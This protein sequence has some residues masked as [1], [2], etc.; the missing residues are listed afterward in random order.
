MKSFSL[1][2]KVAALYV[3]VGSLW[4]IISDV[5][6]NY[7]L[8]LGLVAGVPQTLKGIVFIA[9]TGALLF[10]IIR[11]MD[12]SRSRVEQEAEML[13]SAAKGSLDIIALHDHDGKILFITPSVANTL[14]YEPSDFIN[15]HPS[16]L[17]HPDDIER[18]RTA[19]RGVKEG[20]EQ[21]F[22][23]RAKHKNG[24]YI[25]LESKLK[26]ILDPATQ[27]V[28]RFEAFTRDVSEREQAYRALQQ[29]EA[30]ARNIIDASPVPSALNDKNQRIIYLNPAFIAMFGYTLDDIPTLAEWWVKAYPD[31]VYRQWVQETWQLHLEKA[32]REGTTFEPMEL[33][34]C[35]KDGGKR[36][37][38]VSAAPLGDE[39]QDVHL[40]ILYDITERKAMERALQESEERYR[41]LFN[42]MEEGIAI[43]EAVFDENGDV[44]DYIIVDANP[45]FER[46]SP[47]TIAEALGQRATSLYKME[48]KFIRD[49]WRQ[50]I[51][52]ASV[53][54]TEYYHE[55]SD[56]WFD[57]VT[58]LPENGRFA[59]IFINIT[60]RKRAEEQSRMLALVASKTSNAV[61][62]TDATGY[63]TWVNNGFV[64][65]SGFA[66]EEIIGKKPG[67]LLQGKRTDSETVRQMSR[68]ISA[69]ESFEV[70]VVNYS[71]DG[72]PYWIHI[73]A[74]PFFDESGILQ[75]F[76]AIEQDITHE[77]EQTEALMQSYVETQNFRTALETS[78]LVSITDIRGTIIYANKAFAAVSKYTVEELL[79][80][81]HRLINS[82]FHTQEFFREMWITISSGEP[83]RGEVRNQ[84]KDGSY[85]WVE[86]A[87]SPMLD[88][89]GQIYQYVSVR[90][91]IT[92]RK[93]IEEELQTWS[94][95]L[96]KRVEER[97]HELQE[98]NHEK[99]EILGIA[100]HDLKNPL[101]G[102]LSGAEI[103]ERYYSDDD[104]I[105][106]FATM[107]ISASDQMLG[108]IKNL[109]EIN[110]LENGKF[111]MNLTPISLE[112]VVPIIEDYEQRAKTKDIHVLYEPP[113]GTL[114]PVIMADEQVLWRIVDNIISN[115]LKYSPH[116]K[117]IY[118]RVLS[119]TDENGVEYGRMEVQDEGSGISAEDK[120][121]L[122]GKFARLSAIPTGGE[123]STGLGLSIVKKLTEG[124]NGKVWCESELGQG[125]TFI[126]E[127]PI[128]HDESCLDS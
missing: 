94:Q 109:L 7:I 38:L 34:I 105:K 52:L 49:W 83:W 119:R 69:G 71:K 25:W 1:S 63:T 5:L 51:T 66:S 86:T 108:I 33:S 24:H 87:I 118:V 117:N 75:G 48:S 42:V 70:E 22:T 124:M 44:V 125:A 37:A 54:R 67:D 123:S 26:P 116:G 103:L 65:V 98:L 58:T 73:K 120:K 77:K 35:R 4:I 6:L 95:E 23:Y 89:H 64:N 56:R 84:A 97:T 102:I 29:S 59:T 18:T 9:V 57:I 20:N 78:A 8:H 30:Q 79:G 13:A 32:Q 93:R 82:G 68:A 126:V 39:F 21:Q 90:Y 50:H 111:V 15:K 47:Y 28:V 45:A 107:I 10:L 2:T 36:T 31:E 60:D 85:Y 88:Q 43:N 128:A 46:H 121:K 40:V 101:A 55:P 11:Q 114:A 106:Y 41:N 14:G 91:E 110:V 100:A 127:F 122:F 72:T 76:I 19:I 92:E 17:H 62:I 16:I 74:D 27:K 80:K 113:P 104:K 81:N 61:I 112:V 115:A 53:P 99:D 3:I 12:A 96:E